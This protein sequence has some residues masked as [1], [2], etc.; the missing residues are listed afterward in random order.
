MGQHKFLDLMRWELE[1]YLS[2]PLLAFLVASAI[3]STLSYNGFGA[4]TPYSSLFNGLGTVL[5]IS[6]LV[7]GAFFA[8]SYAGSISRG[9][10]KLLLSYPVKRSQLFLSKFA[11]LFLTVFVIYVPFYSIH[12]YLDGIGTFDFLVFLSLFGLLL[13]LMLACSVAVGI[14]MVTKSEIISILATVLLLFGLDNI[15]GW[16]DPLSAQGRVYHLVQYFGTPI[17]GMSPIMAG[18]DPLVTAGS[19]ALAVLVPIVL[20][21][22]LIAG[23]YLY[24]TRFMEVD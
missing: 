22:V 18:E 14:S 5:L 10:T 24:Y 23:S 6:A 1:E 16:K 19:T 21:V 13:E 2:L 7:A 11:A 12:I 4:P 9:E 20:F 15:L 17:Y 3:I 8:R